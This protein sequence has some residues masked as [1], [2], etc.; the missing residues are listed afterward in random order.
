MVW[1]QLKPIQPYRK[2]YSLVFSKVAPLETRN[3][4]SINPYLVRAYH[5]GL[6]QV[7]PFSEIARNA[8]PALAVKLAGFLAGMRHTIIVPIQIS[9][10]VGASISFSQTP[11]FSERDIRTC[12]ALVHS[13]KMLTEN[14]D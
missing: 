10:V 5:H 4:G 2:N 14:E 11:K 1:T 3:S 6:T 7:A 13:R 12:E 9:G 8:A